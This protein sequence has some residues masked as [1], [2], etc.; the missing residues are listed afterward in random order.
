VESVF[1]A[2]CPPFETRTRGEKQ[3]AR[4]VAW[5]EHRSTKSVLI[6]IIAC[7]SVITESRVYKISI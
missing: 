7:H 5:V 2:Q 3:N 1:D 4:R 6:I